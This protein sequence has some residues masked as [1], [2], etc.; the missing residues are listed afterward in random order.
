MSE[1]EKTTVEPE[2][3]AFVK[4]APELIPLWDWWVKEGK[5]TMVM[6]LAAGVCV[7]AFFGGKSW[8][9]AR[10]ATANGALMN[11]V[12]VEEL[13]EAN[14]RFGS[15]KVGPAI[16]L[17]LGHA[18]VDAGRYEDALELYGKFVKK[19]AADDP[20][21]PVAKLGLAYAQ[22]G[23]GDLAA[24]KESFAKLAEDEQSPVSFTAKLGHARCVALA[25]DKDAAQKELETLKEGADEL[26]KMR[27][28]RLADVIKRHDPNRKPA[29]LL[30]A[31]E[32]AALDVKAEEPAKVEA[33]PAE[34]A[35][36]EVKPAEP[37]VKPEAK[38]A[39]PAKK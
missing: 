7:A 13:E 8:L 28:D 12:T 27:V 36:P 35:K 29:T 39:E 19:A 25:G 33:K 16:R 5:S 4:K 23:G 31:A 10:A 18:Y 21:L 20:L 15:A 6:V 34:A 30:E 17:R 14:A 1:Q 24:A 2:L 38:P 11:A 9:K 3:P 26:G 32:K 37:E 22:E